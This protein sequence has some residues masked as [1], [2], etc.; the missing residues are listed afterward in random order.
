VKANTEMK[1]S[2]KTNQLC[3][4]AS[5]PTVGHPPNEQSTAILDTGCTSH[6][7]TDEMPLLNI[8]EAEEPLTIRNPN[9]STMI[10]T[11][12]ANLDIP[13]L[14]EAATRVHI[15][16]DLAHHSL[17]SVGQLCDAGCVATIDKTSF[18][19]TLGNR[20]IL[21]G[22][23]SP[24]THKLWEINKI[25]KQ[26]E[27]CE[28][29]YATIGSATPANIVTFLH[30]ALFSPALST[31][32]MA[33]S[34][35][36]ITLPGLTVSSLRKHPPKSIAMVKG[37][38]DQIRKNIRSTKQNQ[39][40]EDSDVIPQNDG[41][42]EQQFQNL[43][44]A[45]IFEPTGKIYTDQTGKFV[46][47]SSNGNNYIMI[48]YDY[49]SNAILAEPMPTRTGK[50]MADAY[51]KLHTTLCQAGLKPRT[52]LLDNECPSEM[53]QFM[54]EQGIEYQLV[55][56]GIHRRNAAERA[57]RTFKNHF[58]AGLCSVDSNFPIHLW[59]RL[60]PQAVL[61]INLLRGSRIN[62]KHSA[63]SQ[64]FGPYDFNR[65]PIAPPGTHV[66]AHEKPANRGTWDPHAV[67]AWY[68]G[69]AME[70]YRCYT[71]WIWDTRRERV[72]D[73][74]SWLP[75]STIFPTIT[76]NDII[77]AALIDIKNALLKI[78]TD[79]AQLQ[80][81]DS[82]L[83]TLTKLATFID[84]SNVL[85]NV[86]D[87]Y[88]PTADL[89]TV[90]PSLQEDYTQPVPA[91][92]VENHAPTL[93]IESPPQVTFAPLPPPSRDTYNNSTGAQGRT[94]RRSAK[95]SSTTVPTSHV[96]M[97]R[98]ILHHHGTRAASR[99]K[100]AAVNAVI[101]QHYDIHGNTFALTRNQESIGAAAIAMHYALHGNAFNPDT[102][103]PAEY[104]E[105][106]RSSVGKV[107]ISS[108]SEELLRLL[109]TETIK[110]INVSAIPSGI[111][112]T[113]AC[114]VCAYRPEKENPNRVRLTIGGDRVI[115]H[116][117]VS[118][119]TAD[120]ATVKILINSVLSTPGASFMTLDIK[121]FYLN[122]PMNSNDYAY[123]RIP[124]KLIPAAIMEKYKLNALVHNGNVYV[125]VRK[126]MYGLPQAGRLANDQLVKYLADYGYS[127][128]PITPGLWKHATRPI[129]FTLV[130]DDFGIQYQNRDDVSHLI[131]ALRN[132]Y[133]ISEDWSG[134]R[135]CGLNLDWNYQNCTCD[136]SMPGYIER[137]LQRFQHEP[138]VRPQN[139]PHSWQK[140]EYG[141]TTQ[142]APELD[143]T[144]ALDLSDTKKV[145]EILGT[146]LYY[147]RAVDP[148]L[149]VAI[150]SLAQQQAKPT[151]A[152]MKGVVQLLDYCATHPNSVVRFRSS[153]MILHIESDASYL[154]EPKA[155]SRAAGYHYL[156]SRLPDDTTAPH[157]D[158]PSPPFNGPVNIFCQVLKEVVSSA[159]EAELAGL[160][161]NGKEAC[162]LRIALEEMGY[163]QPPTPIVTDNST[164]AGIANDT[165][166][167]KRS[168][169]I[170][171]RFYW[172][173]DRVR[174]GQ[175]IIYWRKGARNRA[176]YF[177]KHHPTSHHVE[178][179]PVYLHTA[180]NVI[181]TA[182]YY[183]ALAEPD[184]DPDFDTETVVF[185]SGANA[186]FGANDWESITFGP[187]AVHPSIGRGEGVLMP[188]SGLPNDGYLAEPAETAS[189]KST[190]DACVKR[191]ES[192]DC[193]L[194]HS[195]VAHKL[196]SSP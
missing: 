86:V 23:R 138:P 186:H 107:W 110:F 141:A 98:T 15:V 7:C 59:D 129:M 19:V 46:A 99:G 157:P 180:N 27:D 36:Y 52:Q 67:D 35:G 121:D 91:L 187:T 87:C 30:G 92:R 37:H 193:N 16:P 6:F 119:K 12:I 184:D 17:I 38:L 142:F 34:K 54:K 158:D 188:S 162:P 181:P 123:M 63:W 1:K 146:L 71:V 74:L 32:E 41:N 116:G 134:S 13:D 106:S 21:S 126:G 48:L 182:N 192:D 150:G 24:D 111:K 29:A 43:C 190:T 31:L 154:S 161:H 79:A 55:P 97:E 178:M 151:V 101:S 132:F 80:L 28:F 174:Q 4:Y 155:T 77:S 109:T 140:P 22:T 122:T 117:D 156:S 103:L 93:D 14:P 130:V 172:I 72:C 10:A 62:P 112:P 81:S 95:Q 47:P 136:I 73:T 185:P 105:L 9:G 195:L 65:T 5:F 96:P 8:R 56:P 139:A 45:A 120:M 165:V 196:R 25:P 3:V 89:D 68:V 33:L 76:A 94:K 177:T 20:I 113:Y 133:K 152:T 160:F 137:A 125:E 39:E 176:D 135:Y 100:T 51:Q 175:F 145:Q 173:R 82:N 183:A 2:I 69:P 189:L 53:K 168:K 58:I 191:A 194:R 169:A 179:R 49:D 66:L 148:T 102:N 159:A 75:S 42:V 128:C 114:I 26:L 149:L 61:T 108:F 85:D 153:D 166:K 44:F 64:L 50:S 60:L 131:S 18:T 84:N 163:P 164:A 115:Y 88:T 104:D 11:Q 40:L 144:P 171:M 78:P 167:Q 147:A 127:P 57:I 118:T 124:V 170:D 83:E 70:S 90:I 143:H